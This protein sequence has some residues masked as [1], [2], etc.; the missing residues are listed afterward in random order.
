MAITADTK[1][2]YFTELCVCEE[3]EQCSS[4]GSVKQR[5]L[6]SAGRGRFQKGCQQQAPALVSALG[7]PPPWP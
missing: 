5:L 3:P 6:S 2:E 7:I 4:L 1:T